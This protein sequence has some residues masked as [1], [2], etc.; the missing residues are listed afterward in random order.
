MATPNTQSAG[1]LAI[2]AGGGELPVRL[3]EVASNA[4]RDVFVILI[5]G[6]GDSRLQ[7]WP[8]LRWKLAAMGKFFAALQENK[9]SE[10]VMLGQVPRPR[11]R[12]LKFDAG[13]LKYA[14]RFFSILTGG[15]G[16]TLNKVITFLETEGIEVKGAHEVAED[17][18]VSEQKIGKIKPGKGDL[19]DIELGVATARAIGDHD[20]GQGVVIERGRILAI[21]AAEGTDEMLKRCKPLRLATG[22]GHSG[23]LVKVPKPFQDLRLDMP[24]VGIETVRRVADA[25]LAGI[26]VERGHTLTAD[27]M[28][29]AEA[30]DKAGIFVVTVPPLNN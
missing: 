19:R 2:V 16:T 14:P 24:V 5:E 20:I 25:G 23:V 28:G 8:Y 7:R 11:F 22:K 3:A 6:M 15:D 9:C 4:G 27:K 30:A 21:E 12:D 10:L 18:A 13:G 26:A 17:L 29:L 1:T